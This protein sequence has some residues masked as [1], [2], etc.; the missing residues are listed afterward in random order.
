MSDSRLTFIDNIR[1]TT[2]VLVLS[3]HSADTYSPFGN[4]YYTEHPSIGL[5]STLFFGFYQSFLQAFFMG[6]LFFIAGYFTAPSLNSKGIARYLRDRFVRLG[7]PTLL[8]MVAIGPFTEY[9]VAH[10][11]HTSKS[12][13]AAWWEYVS[14]GRIASGSGPMWFCVALLAFNL[15]YAALWKLGAMMTHLQFHS[16]RQPTYG[17]TL[18][19]IAILGGATFLVRVAFPSGTAWLNLQLADFPQYIIMFILG[20]YAYYGDWL[21]QLDTAYCAKWFMAA[22]VFGSALWLISVLMGGA[23]RGRLD[24][25]S[26]GVHWQNAAM[27][28]W[29]SITCVGMTLGLIALFR[30]NFNLQGRLSGLMSANAFSVYLFHPPILIGIA[31]LLHAIEFWRRAQIPPVGNFFLLTAFSVLASFAISNLILIRTPVLKRIL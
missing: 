8:Y 20:I 21:R 6:L 4:W 23:L 2:I 12:F 28:F 7:I 1:W 24:E 19:V 3:M 14:T 16:R 22:I 25:Y 26:G 5:A 27:C 10:S 9:Y 15:V 18:A 29:A 11:W 17:S 31:L 13:P 30:R